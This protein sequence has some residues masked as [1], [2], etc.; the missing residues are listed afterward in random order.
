MTNPY[1]DESTILTQRFDRKNG[2]GCQGDSG[3]P[4]VVENEG[5]FVVVGVASTVPETGAHFSWPPRCFC[6]CEDYPE[7]HARVSIAVPWIKQVMA[8]NKLGLSCA[9]M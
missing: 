7:V 9:R 1:K 5:S 8:E 4:I 6:N 2:F 3:G